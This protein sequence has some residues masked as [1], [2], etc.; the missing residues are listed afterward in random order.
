VKCDL[1]ELVDKLTAAGE[2]IRA[3]GIEGYWLDIGRPED[4]EVAQELYESGRLWRG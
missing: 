3:A 2:H 4:Y 1:P